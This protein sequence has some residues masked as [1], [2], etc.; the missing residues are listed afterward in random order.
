M[1]RFHKYSLGNTMFIGFQKPNAT[2]VAGFH[3]WQKFDRH[4]KRNEKGFTIMAPIV[5][6]RKMIQTP[7]KIT[8]RVNKSRG[9]Q[10]RICIRY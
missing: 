1:G 8:Q 9:V 5:R 10:N 7:K 6:R 3:T 2:H 4:V